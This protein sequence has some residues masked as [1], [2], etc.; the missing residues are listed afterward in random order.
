M[1]RGWHRP[2]L[3]A[4]GGQVQCQAARPP[5]VQARGG[6]LRL[7]LEERE[8]PAQRA[9]A[10]SR[11]AGVGASGPR[12]DHTSGFYHALVEAR[13]PFEMVP[14]SQLDA[15]HL[16]AIPGPGPAQYRQPVRRAVRA[17]A[18]VR[19]KGRRA[20]RHPRDLAQR[21]ARQAPRRFRPRRACSAHRLPAT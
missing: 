21:R 14:D 20:G 6:P 18:G 2:G 8:V 3:P 15:A 10:G 7:A 1:G 17:V 19:R 4:L 16:R 13:I 9:P 11:R 5:L 12:A